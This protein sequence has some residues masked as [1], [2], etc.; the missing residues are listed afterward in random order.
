MLAPLV[1]PPNFGMVTDGVYRSGLP[2]DRH[3]P[4]LDALRLRS[5]VVLCPEGPPSDLAAWAADRGVQIVAPNSV[6]SG[7]GT[8]LR[9]VAALEV[10]AILRDP[11]RHP[12]L[13]TCAAGRYRTGVAV[14]CLRKTQRWTLSAILDEYRRFAGGKAQLENEEFVELFDVSQVPPLDLDDPAA[15]V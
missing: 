8:A 14:G 7:K 11:R 2:E 3:T 6:L 5:V 10:V 15:K 9:E 4:F 13:V 12:L 1:A